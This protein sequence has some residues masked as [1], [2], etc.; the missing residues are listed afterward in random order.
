[1]GNP[2]CIRL[3]L[4]KNLRRISVRGKPE[5]VRF[6]RGPEGGHYGELIINEEVS[7]GK[8]EIC[9][10]L[11]LGSNLGKRKCIHTEGHRSV[12]R[13]EGWGPGLGESIS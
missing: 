2:A 11:R 1:M 12:E 10:V 8:K 4:R 9:A 7:F 6:A 13:V 3:F 5:N